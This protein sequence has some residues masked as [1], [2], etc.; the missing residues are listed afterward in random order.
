ME[1]A[2]VILPASR[3]ARRA[4]VRTALL[5]DERLAWLVSAGHE[6]AFAALYER[7]YQ[8]LYRYSRSM[9]RH[10]ADAQDALQSTMTNAFAALKQGRRDAPL[11]P[12]LFRIAHNE[13]VSVLRRRRPTEELPEDLAGSAA[14]VT[15]HF[16]DRERFALLVAD[17][18][19][20]PE[21]QRGALVMRELSGLSHEEIAIALGSSAGSV[22][23][24]IFEA[25]RSLHN[26]AEGRARALTMRIPREARSFAAST[27]LRFAAAESL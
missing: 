18:L 21:R 3:T 27:S 1:A 14:S 8:P 23:Q 15:E 20:L 10:D 16:E 17:L 24:T 6:R 13:A 9:L 7:Y 5:G 12:W 2:Q 11:R 22:K 26:L 19:T 25:R 4:P